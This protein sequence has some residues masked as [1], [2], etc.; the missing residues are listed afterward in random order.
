M[1]EEQNIIS[2]NLDD[3]ACSATQ[4]E[5]MKKEVLAAVDEKFD[6]EAVAQMVEQL[7]FSK[8]LNG[9]L[10]AELQQRDQMIQYLQGRLDNLELDIALLKR[11]VTAP[12]PFTPPPVIRSQLA[13]QANVP[14]ATTTPQ[15]GLGSQQVESKA[16]NVR[17][18]D[19]STLRAM[20]VAEPTNKF[21]PPPSPEQETKTEST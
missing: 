7:E 20:T 13:P 2:E 3:N 21:V 10:R 8:K 4:W 18:P 12:Y 19:F 15:H 6:V 9:S 16:K 5:A 14:L 1:S 11:T 17:P